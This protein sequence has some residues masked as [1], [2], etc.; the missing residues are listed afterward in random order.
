M[1]PL[2][3][4]RLRHRI[5]IQQKVQT[6]DPYSGALIVTW[7]DFA[8]SIAAAINPVSAKELMAGQ[9]THSQLTTRF[10]IRY[11]PGVDSNMRVLH[12]GTVYEIDGVIPDPDSGL[13]WIT[14]A[15]SS[16]VSDG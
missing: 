9:Q 4:G 15:C 1:K 16:G 5:D 11:R 8:A 14:L 10:V 12:N 2:E 3:S 6:Q 7:A 13:E